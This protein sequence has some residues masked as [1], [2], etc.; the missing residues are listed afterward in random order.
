MP[1]YTSKKL[2]FH[3]A[4]QFKESFYE[5]EPT[6]IGY[7]FIG[8]H[9]TWVNEDSPDSIEDTVADEK[10]VWDNMYAAKKVTGNDVELVV[11]RYNWQNN[12]KYRH[13]DD[14]V[15]LNTLLTPSSNVSLN[16]QPMYVMN[17]ERN[18]YLCISNNL[19]ANSTVEP[20][21]K[22]LTSNG[23]I[24]TGDSY[25]WKYLYNVRASSKFLTNNWIPAPVSTALLDFDT[26]PLISVDG[27][28][29]YIE[30]ESAGSGYVHSNITVDSFQTG[31]TTLKVVSS[32]D[33]SK[34]NLSA[35]LAST[36][37]MA[38]SGTGIGG[39]VYIR[40]IDDVALTITL[41]T[42]ATANGGGSNTAN[43]LALT[44]RVYI[45]GDGTTA[46][47]TP[48]LSGNT[49]QSI[50]MTS[51]GRGYS[52][53]NVQIFGTGTGASARAVLPPKFGHGY[54]SAKQLGATNV[55]VSS[56]IGEIDSS[57]NG[58]ISTQTTFRQYGL[59]RDPHKYG[60]NTDVNTA[61]ANSVISQT[62]DVL[63]ISGTTYN[64][65]EF[66]YQ[67]PSANSAFFSGYINDYTSNEVRLT[68]VKGSPQVGAPLKGANTNPSGRTVVSATNPEFQP[69]TGDI[70]FVENIVK[71]QRIDGQAEN[72][73]FVVRF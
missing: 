73:K 36:A 41:S 51:Y 16:I 72:L 29:A 67:G 2:A 43:T 22:N 46:V 45:D 54:N 19:N 48:I 68:R 62:T 55:M 44:T 13:Y 12:T 59:L 34:P 64:L 27:E 30:L 53:A 20:T 71:T 61:T 70:I 40:S 37:N 1:S 6:T 10:S 26:S 52:S 7:V 31:C 32:T 33:T 57:E 38:V 17:S 58:L 47:A 14:R 42:G 3:N 23:N 69:Y 65:N 4:E 11:P 5:P 35:V 28:L 50:R 18:V 15:D 25:V 63:L 9:L 56:K 8:N 66:V 39:G 60:S 24:Q 21:G 49:I